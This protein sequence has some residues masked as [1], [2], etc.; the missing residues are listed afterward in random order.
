MFTFLEEK[1]FMLKRDNFSK[2]VIAATIES[3]NYG[4]DTITTDVGF[5]VLEIALAPY[6]DL[7]TSYK[8]TY[9]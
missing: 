8:K 1:G 4:I 7:Y 6:K 2:E 5:C 9:T 3:K